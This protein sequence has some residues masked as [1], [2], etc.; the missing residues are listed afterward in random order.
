MALLIRFVS[1]RA[2][3]IALA[4]LVSIAS[5]GPASSDDDAEPGDKN[6]DLSAVFTSIVPNGSVLD[7]QYSYTNSGAE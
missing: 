3:P 2:T 7:Y 4:A 1:P 5:C 6:I